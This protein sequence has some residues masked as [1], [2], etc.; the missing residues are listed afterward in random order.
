MALCWA[1]VRF[2]EV[3][4]AELEDAFEKFKHGLYV[5]RTELEVFDVAAYSAWI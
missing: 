4:E 3:S 1:Q 5:P 2:Y